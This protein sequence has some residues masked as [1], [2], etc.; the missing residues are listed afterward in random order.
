MEYFI[1]VIL[2]GVIVILLSVTFGLPKKGQKDFAVK[3][4]LTNKDLLP[5]TET[6][7][8]PC[9]LCG[10]LLSKNETVKSKLYST[11]QKDSIMDIFG[12]PYCIPPGGKNKRICPVCKKIIPDNGY[13][14]GRFFVKPNK[15]HLHI[16]GCTL[17][18]KA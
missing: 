12:C 6:R 2:L 8:K 4:E 3:R 9:P 16:L 1:I 7:Q 11:K 18:R 14:V 5:K 13:V 10:S 17:C 15:R